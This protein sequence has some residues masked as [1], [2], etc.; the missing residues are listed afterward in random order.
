M[1]F[2]RK[3]RC[4]SAGLPYGK[5]QVKRMSKGFHVAGFVLG[6]LITLCGAAVV[7]LHAAGLYHYR[8]GA[9]YS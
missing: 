5:E 9:R 8:Y 3:F 7:V 2:A 4:R 6:I 1:L